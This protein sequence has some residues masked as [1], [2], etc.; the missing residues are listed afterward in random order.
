[1]PQRIRSL[2][3]SLLPARVLASVFLVLELFVRKKDE[4]RNLN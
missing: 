1:M 4:W 3:P 2:F